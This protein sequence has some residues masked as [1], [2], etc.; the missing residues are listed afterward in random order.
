MHMH[1]V[2]KYSQ[3]NVDVRYICQE[4]KEIFHIWVQLDS[5]RGKCDIS[6]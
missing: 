1:H 4:L 3:L 2:I 5:C 6:K